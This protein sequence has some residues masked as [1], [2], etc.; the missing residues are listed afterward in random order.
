MELTALI[1]LIPTLGFPIVLVIALGWF[2]YKIYKDTTTASKEREEKLYQEIAKN[3]EINARAI[4]TITLY[5]DR[6]DVIQKDISE[7]KTTLTMAQAE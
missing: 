3:Q 7:I 6:L 1:E 2:I 4:E 5:A